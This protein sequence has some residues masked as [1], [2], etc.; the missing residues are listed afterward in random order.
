[1][2]TKKK[3]TK[4][5]DTSKK[6][7]LIQTVISRVFDPPILIILLTAY[8]VYLSDLSKRGLIAMTI[9]IP[10]LFGL[11]LAFFLW[12]MKT[13]KVSNW[14]ISNRKERIIPLLAMLGFLIV[15]I[16]FVS[17]FD[18]PLLLNFF[19]LYF[20]WLL[21]F[22]IIT[23]FWKISGHSGMATLAAGL[24]IEWLGWQAWPILVIV[25]LVSWARVTRHDHTIFQVLAG[26]IYSLV[27]LELW[28]ILLPHY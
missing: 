23:L 18:N 26:V 25:P 19:V 9:F 12:K 6:S 22:F 14:D 8:A 17:L 2:P 20:L 21:G 27:I 15:D 10:F 3:A 16:V 7:F 1:M 11:P 4:I 13:H 5:A 28:F 24:V